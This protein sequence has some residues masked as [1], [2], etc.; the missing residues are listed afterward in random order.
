[1]H[2]RSEVFAQRCLQTNYKKNISS[3][4][5]VT[6]ILL[7]HTLLEEHDENAITDVVLLATCTMQCNVVEAMTFIFTTCNS[8]GHT[9][10]RSYILSEIQKC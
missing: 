10:V 5:E 8:F 2:I 4:A 9:N 1:M 6:S 7:G 3:L